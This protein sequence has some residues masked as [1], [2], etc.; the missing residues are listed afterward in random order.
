MRIEDVTCYPPAKKFPEC[1]KPANLLIGGELHS[2]IAT[3][4]TKI[5]LVFHKGKISE[6]ICNYLNRQTGLCE[7]CEA[8]TVPC[9]YLPSPKKNKGFKALIAKFLS[10]T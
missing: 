7:W 9:R 1:N 6:V 5:K 8:K 2:I 4:G 10:L 3:G